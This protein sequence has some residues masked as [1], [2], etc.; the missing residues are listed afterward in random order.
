MGGLELADH[1]GPGLPRTGTAA[2]GIAPHKQLQQ[3]GPL[4]QPIEG[5]GGLGISTPG[6]GAA[7]F[8]Q[9]GGQPGGFRDHQGWSREGQ[10]GSG[11]GVVAAN[12]V[13]PAAAGD[14]G[15][16]VDLQGGL[17]QLQGEGPIGF[18]RLSRLVHRL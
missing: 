9:A 12:Q 18:H 11:E 6:R 1:L 16:T 3:H 4:G 13:H 8:D 17:H 15:R 2:E 10:E 14:P 5:Q 7:G